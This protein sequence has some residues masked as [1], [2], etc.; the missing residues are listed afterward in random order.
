MFIRSIIEFIMADNDLRPDVDIS[1]I[2]D[3]EFGPNS[4]GGLNVGLLSLYT[5][6]ELMHCYELIEVEE[7][8]GLLP[9]IYRMYNAQDL[10]K[11]E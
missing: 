5:V 11:F 4:R 7:T 2:K 6:S 3:I 10:G 1:R 8:Q 9:V